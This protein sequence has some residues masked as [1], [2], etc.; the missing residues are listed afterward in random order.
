MPMDWK[1]NS[2]VALRQ[3]EETNNA[4]K[5]H[6]KVTVGEFLQNKVVFL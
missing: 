5:D 6:K 2:W 4:S 3:P 1:K